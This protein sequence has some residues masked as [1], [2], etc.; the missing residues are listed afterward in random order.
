MSAIR[1]VIE[2]LDTIEA[3]KKEADWLATCGDEEVREAGAKI[4]D[5]CRQALGE[6]E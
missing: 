2:L 5:L 1:E 3:I 6:E 4:L